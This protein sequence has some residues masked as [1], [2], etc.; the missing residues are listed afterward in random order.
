MIS[1]DSLI[2][3]GPHASLSIPP[4]IMIFD[5]EKKIQDYSFPTSDDAQG[6]AIYENHVFLIDKNKIQI[7]DLKGELLSEFKLETNSKESSSFSQIE[8]NTNTLYVLDTHALQNRL[9]IMDVNV[10]Q[11]VYHFV[12][13]C[14]YI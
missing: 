6:V 7:F 11:V 1:S 12:L 14:G 3:S 13:A 9:K 4:E 8:V 5:K 10:R 2:A